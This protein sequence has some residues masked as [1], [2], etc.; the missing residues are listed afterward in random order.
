M[1]TIDRR[2]VIKSAGALLGANACGVGRS[3]AGATPAVRARLSIDPARELNRI[4]LD[5]IGFSIETATLANAQ[6]YD[7]GNRSLV[8]LFKRLTPDGVLRI[9]GNSSEF[10]WWKG[11][12]SATVPDIRS[13]GLGRPDNWMPQRLT[14]ITP[15]AIDN[16]RGFLDATGWTCIYGLNFG[17]GAPARDAE[18]AEYVARTLG[19]RLKYFQIGNE[20]DFYRQPNNRLREPGWDFPDYLR[21][22]LAIAHGVID[23]VPGARFGGPDV[24]SSAE[25]VVRFGNEA[26]PALGNRL[27]EL[28]GHYYAEGP[29][30]SP[31]ASIENLLADDPRI[32]E[33]MD[34]IMPVAQR[35]ALTFR[36]AE[37]NSC[38]R[39][40]KAGM[41]NALAGAL[42]GMDYLLGMA[43]RGC[44]GINL[45]GGGGAEISSAL[46]DK[47][48]GARDARDLEIAK[49][50]T[51]YSPIAGNT[52]VGYGARPIYYGMLAVQQLVDR[53]LVQTSLEASGVNAKAYAARNETGW[54]IAL[55]NK[56][57][58]RDLEVEIANPSK[59]RYATIW[60]LSAP[61]I[62][63]T[64]R[65]TLA[66]AEVSG[67]GA[68][69]SPR[70][71]ER[72]NMRSGVARVALPH[73]SAAV[74]FFD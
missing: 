49:L 16:L 61:A 21:E 22:W 7:A 57:L 60:R 48:P 28:T 65:V 51:F 33:R 15:A 8:S 20:P 38:Y 73:A 11:S 29:P 59:S 42:W 41:S 62:D 64:E 12:A 43:A 39:G 69:W 32:A 67:L 54:R 31:N 40:G 10:C 56:D 14:A 53:T 13:A 66:N 46:G 9:G 63:A 23:R 52:T 35:N 45:H 18:E 27:T 47:L 34:A 19:T 37:G 72:I 36:M 2:T 1:K 17:T 55:I 3:A 25:W 26:A 4:P 71:V 6:I 5:Y 74:V 30:D 24:G 70:G 44:H 50:G 58:Q 68:D